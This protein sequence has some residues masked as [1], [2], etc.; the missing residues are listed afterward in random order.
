MNI[1]YYG[2]SCFK[3]TT[4]PEGRGAEDISLFIDPFE[5]EV[6][7]KPPQGQADIV[8]ISHGHFDHNNTSSLKGEPVIINTPGEFAV[9]GLHIIGLD[10]FHD[11][12]EGA[13]R[14]R[15]TVFIIETEDLRI[16]HMG[17]IGTE[18]TPEQL[19]E[20]G[21]VDVLMIPVGGTFTLDGKEAM[22]LVHKI[23]PKTVIPMH[24]KTKDSKISDIQ[25]EKEFCDEMGNCP[26]EKIN[27]ITLKKKD[28]EEKGM[29]IVLMTA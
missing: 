8:L 29:E 3:I 20:I 26:K 17:D 22:K 2:H 1:Q 16:C 4:K 14:G 18:P 25:D 15:N 5:K 27:K 9:K 7:L 12:S 28:S 10:T 24:Y 13:E 23:E 19:D 6:G 21:E 11:K